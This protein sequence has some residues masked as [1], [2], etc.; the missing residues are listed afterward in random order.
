MTP[1]LFGLLPDGSPVHG[2]TIG[3]GALRATL[4]TH[5]ARLQD[6][7]LAGVAHPLVLGSPRLE[8]Y[9][10]P[11][12]YFG[13]TVG[14]YAN[15]I[16]GGRFSLD[17]RSYQLDR[18]E[19]G[20]TCLHGGSAGTG[21]LNW[22]LEEQTPDS[23]TFALLLADGDMGFPGRC[24][25]S[26]TYRVTGTAL[27]I[28]MEAT[29]SAAC[30]ISLAHHSYFCLDGAGDV[31]GQTLQ[32][33]AEHYLPVDDRLIPLG[34]ISPVAA[35]PFDFRTPRQIGPHGYDHNFCLDG[36]GPAARLTGRDGL[37]LEVET[38]APGLQVYNAAH[39]PTEGLPGLDGLAYAPRAGLAMETQEWPDAPNHDSFPDPVIR[40]GEVYR[41]QTVYRFTKT[42]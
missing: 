35:T 15:R 23:A 36:D 28:T 20:Q 5:G 9:L 34:E 19:S 11:M 25:V 16:A 4:L 14:R 13:A 6:L 18:N 10:G 40:P 1:A 17:G 26:V 2:V 33:A 8:D 7:R 12:N 22:S 27:E 30:P 31:A 32:I 41:N 37:V 39:L 29:P 24:A 21:V 3:T 42:A 38:D